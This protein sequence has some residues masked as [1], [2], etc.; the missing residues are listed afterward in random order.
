MICNLFL[1]LLKFKEII[2]ISK[3]AEEDMFLEGT[4][5]IVFDHENKIAY[6]ARSNRTNIN[7]LKFVCQKLGYSSAEF[8]AVD[9]DGVP[10]YHTNVMMWIGTEVAAICSESIIDPKVTLKMILKLKMQLH[11][12]YALMY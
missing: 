12:E 9:G 2:D 7:L 6:A 10:I 4:G 1:S 5:S 8:D 11:I 3:F